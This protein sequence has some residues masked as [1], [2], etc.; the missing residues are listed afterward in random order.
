MIREK[1]KQRPCEAHSIEALHRDGQVCSS[2]ETAVM[3]VERRDL[4]I[5]FSTPT[6]NRRSD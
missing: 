6:E 5:Q 3:A 1:H 2:V 4:V